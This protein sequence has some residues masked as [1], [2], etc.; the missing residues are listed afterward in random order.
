[1]QR[2][3][4][5]SNSLSHDI[6][7]CI[8]H[9]SYISDGNIRSQLIPHWQSASMI[10]LTERLDYWGFGLWCQLHQA[11]S[12]WLTRQENLQSETQPILPMSVEICGRKRL[13]VN[14][15][16]PS[17]QNGRAQLSFMAVPHYRMTIALLLLL[18]LHTSH[19]ISLCQNNMSPAQPW[20]QSVKDAGEPQ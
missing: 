11:P 7:T 20:D 3:V 5:H 16:S 8:S 12:L 4:H 2:I 1:M 9:N 18:H 15:T 14:T 17:P 19:L 6:L 10:R 13:V